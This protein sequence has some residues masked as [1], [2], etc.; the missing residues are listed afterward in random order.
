MYKVAICE[1]ETNAN[2]NL[3][4]LCRGILNK[5][6]VEHEIVQF[7]AC[8]ELEEALS[9]GEQFNL[10]CLDIYMPQKSGMELA[11]QIRERDDNVVTCSMEHILEGYDVRP[12]Q[13]LLKP[14]DEKKL[15]EALQTDLRLHRQPQEL[16]LQL[17]GRTYVIPLAEIQYIESIN[18]GCRFHM[19]QGEQFFWMPLSQVEKLLPQNQFC[20]CHQSFIVNLKEIK[21]ADSRSV[22]LSDGSSLAIGPKYAASFKNNFVHFLNTD[23]LK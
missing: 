15:E 16:T 13:Y 1:D 5:M 12:I 18:H 6:D 20:R 22:M 2:E 3:K 14:V 19:A 17:G 7:G 11:R 21:T 4:A 9:R 23:M 10:L 8:E